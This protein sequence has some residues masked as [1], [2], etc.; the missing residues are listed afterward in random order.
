MVVAFYLLV[1]L[2]F[3]LYRYLD[4]GAYGRWPDWRPDFINE[5]TGALAALLLFF[6]V[7]HFANRYPLLPGLWQRNLWKYVVALLVWSP[8][9]TTLMALMRAPLY[10]WLVDQEFNYGYMPVRFLMEFS[11]DCFTFS[12][13]VSAI[14][15]FRYQWELQQRELRAVQ[16][17]KELTQAHLDA[18][19]LQLRPHFLFNALNA[20]SSV[21]YEDARKADRMI[22]SLSEF[23]RATLRQQTTQQTTLGEELRM[24]HRYLDIM[25]VRFGDRLIA[26]ED[27]PEALMRARV[28]SLLLQPL[29]ENCVQHGVSP[30]DG[31]LQIHLSVR[32]TDGKLMLTLRDHGPGLSTTGPS[33]H[34]GHGVG[35]SNTRRRLERLYGEHQNLQLESAPD[36]GAVL[37]VMLPLQLVDAE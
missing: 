31:V 8:I 6:P 5:T 9:H 11:V 29:V 37:T 21:M 12:A 26:S 30:T 7:F 19:L 4:K 33:R 17:E 36:G 35:L 27:V 10:R 16:L 13:Q 22:A 34:A 32:S 14:T 15:A 24:L 25:Q 2:F 20:V 18:L 3:F 23:L 1:G 28:P